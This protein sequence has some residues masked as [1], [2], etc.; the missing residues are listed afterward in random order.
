MTAICWGIDPSTQRIA[1][2]RRGVGHAT[3]ILSLPQNANPGARVHNTRAAALQHLRRLAADGH[4]SLVVVEQPFAH[5][6]N[7]YPQSFYAVGALLDALWETLGVSAEVLMLG[8]GEWR[9]R[10]GLGGRA[11]KAE[12]LR[13][14][15]TLTQHGLVCLACGNGEEPTK[16]RKDGRLDCRNPS[17]AHD[18]A[19]AL[20]CA[21]AGARTLEQRAA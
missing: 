10:A 18:R 14:A 9:A 20:G 1:F 12:T 5:G 13:W 16:A 15:R 17:P 8:P 4:P 11:T 2:G 6:N 7:V 3:S 21:V 19:D